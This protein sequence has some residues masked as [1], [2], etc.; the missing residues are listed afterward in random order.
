MV[1]LSG[2]SS[3]NNDPDS[4]PFD[5]AA[6]SADVRPG[7]VGGGSRV[8]QAPHEVSCAERS[9]SEARSPAAVAKRVDLPAVPLR[10][11]GHADRR[12]RRTHGPADRL[13]ESAKEAGS[14]GYPCRNTRSRDLKSH[15]TSCGAYLTTFAHPL[16]E[17]FGIS[18]NDIVVAQTHLVDLA[19]A[20]RETL[21]TLD[22]LAEQYATEES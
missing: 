11:R 7:K 22:E 15:E 4:G 10:H 12:R 8:T 6:H 1:R 19:A 2:Y 13:T 20:I 18:T 5:G 16:V 21:P 17:A 3:S 14:R 9:G